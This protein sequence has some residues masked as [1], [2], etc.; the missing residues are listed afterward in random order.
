MVH[1]PANGIVSRA[2]GDPTQRNPEEEENLIVIRTESRV[3]IGL[4]HRQEGSLTVQKADP[5]TAN[6]RAHL[7]IHREGSRS[8]RKK[9]A[10]S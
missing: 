8:R 7:H 5:A 1:S 2:I 10:R 6:R 9:R 4:A 3:D